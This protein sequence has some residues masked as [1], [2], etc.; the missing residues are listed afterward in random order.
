MADNNEIRVIIT[1]DTS[2]ERFTG[3]SGSVEDLSKKTAEEAITPKTSNNYA[4]KMGKLA[5]DKATGG[6]VGHME[7]VVGTAIALTSNPVAIAALALATASKMYQEFR[8]YQRRV[9]D[10]KQVHLRAGGMHRGNNVN[11]SDSRVSAM[12]GR[13]VGGIE[14]VR[15]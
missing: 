11:L 12:T 15:R 5:L 10:T 6:A 4:G 9:E 8:D 7:G 13:T 1:D 3:G 2:D 14:T